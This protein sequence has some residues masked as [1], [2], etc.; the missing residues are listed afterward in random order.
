MVQNNIIWTVVSEDEQQFTKQCTEIASLGYTL[1]SS[2]CLTYDVGEQSCREVKTRFA[3]IFIRH[4]YSKSVTGKYRMVR[5][6][7]G[8]FYDKH[9]IITEYLIDEPVREFSGVFLGWCQV[10][11]GKN[12]NFY[13]VIETAHHTILQKLTNEIRFVD[14]HTRE[15]M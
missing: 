2:S 7:D 5:Y 14:S 11:V 1:D 12:M 3:A 4:E 9:G 13:A 8:G 6:L 10:S 15:V